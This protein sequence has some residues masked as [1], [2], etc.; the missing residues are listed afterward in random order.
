MFSRGTGPNENSQKF[1]LHI[2]GRD[3]IE[4]TAAKKLLTAQDAEEQ[5]RTR[6]GLLIQ[7]PRAIGGGWEGATVVAA[8]D[9]VAVAGD[10]VVGPVAE[11]AWNQ[12]EDGG[13]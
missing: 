2:R 13:G 9:L 10:C 3:V 4:I 5:T 6:G 11:G 8:A 7:E 12:A 1:I